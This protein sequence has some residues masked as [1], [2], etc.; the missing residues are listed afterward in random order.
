MKTALIPV[1]PLDD[2]AALED[3]IAWA[4]SPRALLMW[5]RGGCVVQRTF[6]FVRLRRIADRLGTQIA[7]VTRERR[8]RRVASEVGIPVFATR[9][10]AMRRVWRWRRV[11]APRPRPRRMQLSVLRQWARRPLPWTQ[12]KTWQQWLFFILGVLAVGLVAAVVFP[13]ARIT[14]YPT[15]QVQQVDFT[16]VISPRYTTATLSG[17]LPARWETVTVGVQE[18]VPVSGTTRW[19][20]S[21]AQT[22][23]SF[24][25]LTDAPVKIPKGTRVRSIAAP[26]VVFVTTESGTVPAG[27]GRRVRLQVVSLSRGTEANRP[28]HDL[29]VLEPPL[30]FQVT[31]DNLKA[32]RGGRNVNAPA[33]SR[34]DY[35]DLEHRTQAALDT[36]ALAALQR[37][38]PHDLIL[39]PSLQVETLLENTFDPPTPVAANVLALT[40]R[41]RYRALLV[42]RDD[43]QALAQLMLD[44]RAPQGLR[45]MSESVT[46]EGEAAGPEAQ[47]DAYT[48]NFHVHGTFAAPVDIDAVRQH[49][50]GQ[51]PAA[52]QERLQTALALEKPP[53]ITIWPSWWQRL[54][55]LPLRIRIVVSSP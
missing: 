16:A 24:A 23:V 41:A 46:I 11:R 40:S 26:D 14:L 38:F 1:D 49:V 7:V 19:P 32:A 4:K 31:A 44:A 5:P 55:W 34:R 36:E 42:S 48:W 21:P 45:L 52:A 10:E 17:Q 54:P 28:A 15:R 25:N 47:G 8:V 30:A 35:R 51:T 2:L 18:T 50:L 53:E 33:P 3:K 13:G 29:R 37:Q 43:L 22:V 27:V 12:L 20:S 9:Q 6:D 39:L